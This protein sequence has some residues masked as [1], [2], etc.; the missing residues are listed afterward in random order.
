[1]L[2]LAAAAGVLG[3]TAWAL[4]ATFSQDW[5]QCD[6]IEGTCIRMRQQSA[7]VSIEVLALV[8]AAPAAWCVW[9]MARG[10]SGRWLLVLVPCAL[11]AASILAV[12]PIPHLND[13][14]TGW[15]SR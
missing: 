1:V 8:A 6:N 9:L 7:I 11:V 2:R 12:D 14:R 4:V 3:L 10:R 13:S 15:L 5:N